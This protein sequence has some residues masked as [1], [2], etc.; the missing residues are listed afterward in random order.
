MPIMIDIVRDG[1]AA[2]QGR[3]LNVLGEL[4]TDWLLLHKAEAEKTVEGKTL[5]GAM[6]AIM[7]VA[8]KQGGSWGVVDDQEGLRIA[9]AYLGADAKT[10]GDSA[11]TPRAT[12]TAHAATACQTDSALDLDAL[13]GL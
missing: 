6:Q 10:A 8:R 5:S 11:P 4:L 9:L 7:E 2:A 13:L 12:V 3:S 1:M